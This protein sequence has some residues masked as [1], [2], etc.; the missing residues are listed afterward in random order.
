MLFSPFEGFLGSRLPADV[1]HRGAA[2]LPR[3]TATRR[4]CCT[5]ASARPR[6][7]SG[8]RRRVSAATL[9]QRERCAGTLELLVAAP[10]P[11]S[12]R[13]AADHGCAMATSGSTAGRHDAVGLVAL[14]HP[15][16]VEN[17]PV[18]VLSVLMATVTIALFGFLLSVTAVR[19]RTAWALGRPWSTPA[20]CSCGFVVPARRCCPTGCFG[21]MSWALR[22]DLGDRG[23]ARRRRRGESVGRPGHLPGRRPGYGLLA[24]AGA[25]WLERPS[26]SNVGPP[27]RDPGADVTRMTSIRIFF[28][29]GLMS[30][31][32]LFNWM[33]PWIFVPHLL[34]S[35]V[36]QIL[37]F[38]YI[39]RSAGVG[40]R[41]VLRDRQRAQLRRD[42]VHVRD[43]LHDRR[44][45][46]RPDA[47]LVLITPRAGSRCSSAG[48]CR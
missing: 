45:A 10:T 9:L 34:V 18:F 38:A 15:L 3:R 6:W 24:A 21:R 44:R 25:A 32:A 30:F 28:V 2:R 22:A 37:L 20:G 7:A 13:A 1:R 35:P 41:R 42:P 17:W 29:G 33:S 36:C 31:R 46:L 43:D 4:P 27:R 11:F 23:D 47:G 14:R 12:L 39:G 8:P 48:R 5:P 40:Q 16:H 19:Y 26:R